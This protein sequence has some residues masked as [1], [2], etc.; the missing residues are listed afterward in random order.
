MHF[1][2][3]PLFIII[4][5]FMFFYWIAVKMLHSGVCRIFLG[6]TFRAKTAGT[7]D[8]K[9][10]DCA[11]PR[12][13]R[14]KQKKN[15]FPKCVYSIGLQY[16]ERAMHRHRSVSGL[17]LGRAPKRDSPRYCSVH[18]LH[19]VSHTRRG[20]QEQVQTPRNTL[21]SVTQS[22]GA[23]HPALP[24]AHTPWWGEKRPLFG[25]RPLRQVGRV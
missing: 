12:P 1:S 13:R 3:F 9:N 22:R 10:I 25:K 15:F 4:I 21:F 16:D 7:P 5:N 2:A 6:S 23:R 18:R 20:W 8:R 24:V 11:S 14:L 19:C 17:G